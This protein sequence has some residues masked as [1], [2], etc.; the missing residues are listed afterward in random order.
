MNRFQE[1][2]APGFA[3]HQYSK[4][5]IIPAEQDH[6]WAVLMQQ[7]TFRDT[8]LW[9]YKVEFA[10][11]EDGEMT[12]GMENVHHGPL[13]L[14]TG[15][16]TKVDAPNYRELQY[17]LGSYFLSMRLV[18]PTRLEFHLMPGEGGTRVR[19]T[20]SSQVKPYFA[21]IWSAMLKI[22]WGRF[23][24]W[25]SRYIRKHQPVLNKLDA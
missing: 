2:L 25:I 5:Y 11:E 16:I 8:Q 22:F 15:E 18:R 19:L 3:V 13:M 21:G 23:G 7:S 10:T 24:T 14:F 4:E 9:P 20:L 1:K 12:V 6:V 17:Y